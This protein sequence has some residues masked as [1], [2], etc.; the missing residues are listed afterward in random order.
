MQ[1]IGTRRLCPECNASESRTQ[2][3]TPALSST[4]SCH[5][6]LTSLPSVEAATTSCAS[7][8]RLSSHCLKSPGVRILS[9]GLLQLSVLWY[10]GRTDWQT[11]WPVQNTIA[12][13]VTGHIMKVLPSATL[14]TGMPARLLQCCDARSSVGDHWRHFCLDHGASSHS[15]ISQNHWLTSTKSNS[16]QTH[17]RAPN[18]NWPRS[19]LQTKHHFSLETR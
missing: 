8:G 4:A 13:L 15:W 18:L 19:E 6:R 10:L 1:R 3:V 7:Y 2:P 5:C 12:R 9:P 17:N 14:A 11:G 16:I